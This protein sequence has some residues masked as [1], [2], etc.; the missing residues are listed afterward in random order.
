MTGGQTGNAL[1]VRQ[2]QVVEVAGTAERLVHHPQGNVAALVVLDIVRAYQQTQLFAGLPVRVAAIQYPQAVVHLAGSIDRDG[3]HGALANKLGD[4]LVA[5]IVVQVVRRVSLGHPSAVQQGHLVGHGKGLVLVVGDQDGGDAVA[6]QQFT[7][8]GG[9]FRAQL[10]IQ[11]GE[12]FVQQQDLRIRRQRPGQR[13]PLLLAAGQLVG[14]GT[15]VF[16][17]GDQLQHALHPLAPLLARQVA[18]PEADI[19]AHVEMG[20]QGEILEHHAHLALFRWQLAPGCA[21]GNAAQ[22]NAA[23]VDAL[24][25]GDGAQQRGLA[26]A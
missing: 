10:C 15:A 26:A 25:S 6:L 11:A 7:D 12:G 18:E 19:A 4:E 23:G 9:Q 20:K 1:A 13:H 5:G 3:D 17:Q 21:D 14:E 24:K 2:Q 22:G 8:F 16:A